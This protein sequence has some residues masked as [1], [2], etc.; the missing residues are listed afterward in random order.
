MTSASRNIRGRQTHSNLCQSNTRT[1][2]FVEIRCQNGSQ[3]EGRVASG[4]EL[5]RGGGGGVI[6][7]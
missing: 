3:S 6:V 2:S 7:Q 1:F 4:T 5:G